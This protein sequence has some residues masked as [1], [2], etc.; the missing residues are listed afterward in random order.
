M[1]TWNLIA[2]SAHQK[3]VLLRGFDLIKSHFIA[4]IAD[5]SYD[6]HASLHQLENL[7]QA[8]A[9]PDLAERV[10]TALSTMRP[11][12]AVVPGDEGLKLAL[13]LKVPEIA[14]PAQSVVPAP[15]SPDEIAAWQEMLDD[16]DAFMVF[17]IKQLAGTVGDQPR[18]VN[19]RVRRSH[20]LRRER[21]PVVGLAVDTDRLR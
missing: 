13:E 20:P 1:A 8:A 10:N 5:F 4:R 12:S 6:L 19:L 18:H 3:S 15:L 7:L 16:W 14:T 2:K 21:Q 17:A 9:A 11:M